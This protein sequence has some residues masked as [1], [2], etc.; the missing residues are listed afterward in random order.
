MMNRYTRDP[1]SFAMLAGVLFFFGFLAAGA[2]VA[3]GI[4]FGIVQ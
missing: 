1:G 4:L 2:T 3:L